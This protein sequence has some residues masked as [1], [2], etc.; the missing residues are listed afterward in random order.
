MIGS[1]GAAKEEGPAVL[2]VS[3]EPEPYPCRRLVSQGPAKA[4]YV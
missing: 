2:P 1:Q 3:W 4:S